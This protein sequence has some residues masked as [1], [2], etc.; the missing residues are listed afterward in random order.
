MVSQIPLLYLQNLA[1]F[2]LLYKPCTSTA[3]GKLTLVLT[4]SALVF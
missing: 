1:N 4:L 3:F 2:N